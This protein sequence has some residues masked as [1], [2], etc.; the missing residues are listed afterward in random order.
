VG[1]LWDYTRQAGK[2]PR[3]HAGS[4]RAVSCRRRRRRRRRRQLIA[5]NYQTSAARTYPLP[6]P[7]RG[8]LSGQCV[9]MLPPLSVIPRTLDR[10]VFRRARVLAYVGIRAT[11]V[12]LNGCS[13][14]NKIEEIKRSDVRNE[15]F[16]RMPLSCVSLRVI[17]DSSFQR[18][19]E[20]L[21]SRNNVVQH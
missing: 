19:D 7:A 14:S 12:N 15:L 16:I 2:K 13:T 21:T 4:I 9:G 5:L 6:L 20:N 17:R 3:G 11:T 8:H 1:T 18:H 10:C